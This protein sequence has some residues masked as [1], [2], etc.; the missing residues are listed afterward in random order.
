MTHRAILHREIGIDVGHRVPDHGSKCRNPHGHRYRIIATCE[1]PV[2]DQAGNEENGMVVDFGNVKRYMMD[3]LDSVF[4]HGFVVYAYD[5]ALM[6]MFFPGSDPIEVLSDYNAAW[7][8]EKTTYLE[9]MK[10]NA[11]LSP[12]K[13]PH[14]DST[15]QDP[16]GLKVIVV[17]YVPTAEN[18]AKHMF[19]LLSEPVSAH[20]GN[21][22]KLVNI[23]LYETPNGW[24]DY[25][26]MHFRT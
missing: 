17:D 14:T 10:K 21:D 7:T 3:W 26:G 23:R 8:E 6:N 13:L 4:D 2:L 11:H 5:K 12:I 18:L 24:V 20:Y 25:P 15:E 19:E 22:V 16:T 9:A 1:G